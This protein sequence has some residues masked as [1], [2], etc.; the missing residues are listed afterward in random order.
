MVNKN[1]TLFKY[2]R[3]FLLVVKDKNEVQSFI[4]QFKL[5][6]KG[7]EKVHDRGA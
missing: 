3:T 6:S 4:Y 1:L 5:D 7:N 2:F